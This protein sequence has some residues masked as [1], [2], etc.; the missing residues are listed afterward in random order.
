MASGIVEK[1]TQETSQQQQQPGASGQRARLVQELIDAANLPAFMN[2]LLTA[3]A[4][5]VV[6]TEAAGFLIERGAENTMGLRPIAHVRPDQSTPEAR[7]AAL[8]A[9]QDLVR[10]CIQQGK[11]GAIEVAGPNDAAESQVCLV[12]L[13][14]ADNAVVAVSRGRDAMHESRTRP[15]AAFVDAACRRLL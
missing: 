2:S 9:F 8:N 12:T 4:V 15:A 1:S 11:D 5:T 6:G 14:R 7:T 3:Q 10:P 13:L